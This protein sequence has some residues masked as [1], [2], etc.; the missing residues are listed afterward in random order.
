MRAFGKMAVVQAK[1]YLRE[2][3]AVFFT[4]LFGP[5]LVILLGLIF[6]NKPEAMFGG[7]GY[8]DMSVPG[9]IG[10]VI[11]ITSLTTIPITVSTRREMGVLR[12]YSVTPL[13]PVTYF[14]ADILTTFVFT[15]TGC[16]LSF[17]TGILVF[18]TRFDGN[19]FSVLGGLCLSTI[20]FFSL[21]YAV[22]GLVPNVRAATVFGNIV[23][24][25]MNV[26]SGAMVPI[27]AMPAGV[28]KTAL[29]IPLTHVVTLLQGLWFADPWTAHWLEV[30]V[31][32]GMTVVGMAV[33][34]LTFKWE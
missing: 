9:F 24:I 8:L 4:V 25:P 13:K 14:L 32:A 26:L 1:L 33:V 28:Q 21:G 29:F 10:V 5:A 11:A 17:L 27:Q 34:A 18:H 3:M 19:L 7:L 16:L 22:A 12:R 23:V 30:A 2:P 31:L 15:L 6:G 20:A